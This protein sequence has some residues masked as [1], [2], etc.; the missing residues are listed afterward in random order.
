VRG[1]I[2]WR[3]ATMGLKWGVDR[4]SFSYAPLIDSNHSTSP[5]HL[6]FPYRR[7]RSLIILGFSA[8]PPA[9]YGRRCNRQSSCRPLW[10]ATESSHVFS[11]TGT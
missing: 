1:M 11:A 2:A 7:P 4:R 6:R 8:V 10:Y 3:I 9:G 5:S